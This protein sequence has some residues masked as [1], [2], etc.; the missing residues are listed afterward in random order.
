MGFGDIQIPISTSTY[1]LS[2]PPESRPNYLKTVVAGYM[3]A[4]GDGRRDFSTFLLNSY[5]NGPGRK[6]RKFHRWANLPG[7]YSMVGVPTAIVN[8]INPVD[9]TA[10]S[11]HLSIPE[12][13]ILSVAVG[14]ANYAWWARQYITS[15]PVRIAHGATSTPWSYTVDITTNIVTVTVPGSW[16]DSF[17]AA[18]YDTTATYIY[19]LASPSIFIPHIF[20]Y[21]VGSGD[22]TLDATAEE[23]SALPHDYYPPIPIRTNNVFL[24]SLDPTAYTE[25]KQ[26]YKRAFNGKISDIVKSISESE[27]VDD[28]DYANIVFGVPLNTTDNS[29]RKYLY[30]FFSYLAP[31]TTSTELEGST[32]LADI[33]SFNASVAAWKSWYDGGQVGTAP[34]IDPFPQGRGT[35]VQLVTNGAI[36]TAQRIIL[37]WNT[38][39]ETTGS[40]LLKPDAEAGELW[41]DSDPSNDIM[42]PIEDGDLGVWDTSTV[43]RLC[44][45]LTP[46]TWKM[47]TISNLVYKDFVAFGEFKVVNALE[48]LSDPAESAF[49]VPLHEPTLTAM[50]M[51]GNTQ[52]AI[53]A[54]YLVTH[55]YEV[56]VP[57]LLQSLSIFLF[58]A[59]I[60]V[61]VVLPPVGGLLGS[62][63]GVGTAIGLTGA[64]AVVAG[65]IINA[66]A[67]MILMK[68][69]TVISVAV[70][71]DKLGQLI[72]AIV[73]FVAVNV[74]TGLANGMSMSAMWGSM[75]SATSL[76]QLTSAVGAGFSGYVQAALQDMQQQMEDLTSST[77]SELRKVQE[78]YA[79]N[80]GY[81]NG[82]I[83]PMSLTDTSLGNFSETPSQ[84]LNRTLLTGSDIADISLGMLT[85]FTDLTLSTDLNR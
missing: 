69:I 83:D 57:G 22:T 62:N 36:A 33:A 68:I 30:R 28:I 49:L 8:G 67:A 84:F 5:S 51:I 61:T 48:A 85:N 73:G 21:R 60:V 4:N 59:M 31:Y 50:G 74:G 13:K 53:G 1:A 75:M 24:E 46:S 63:L 17:T 35:E 43:V 9:L 78:L 56:I 45:Q 64:M 79:K 44:W 7:N 14:P 26:A 80:I 39:I 58:V 54:A 42:V 12:E 71:G 77:N 10:L 23:L 55:S 34:V 2:G 15:T 70:L 3:L 38:I 47:L 18:D 37:S 82:V 66:L 52:L 41:F 25:T 81:G 76:L 32:Y 20:I 27:S 29:S 40:G 16:S 19:V 11:A 72:G 65:T 6:I